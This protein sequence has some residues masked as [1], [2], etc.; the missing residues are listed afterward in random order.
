MLR[1]INLLLLAFLFLLS[2][3]YPWYF[4]VAVPFVALVGGAPGWALTIG[5]FML[6]DVVPDD[7]QVHFLIRDAVFN[8][9]FLVA[10]VFELTRARGQLAGA[11]ARA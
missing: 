1:D 9:L 2:P 4:L 7:P 5:G 11:Q 10:V 3:D 8:G 6:Y